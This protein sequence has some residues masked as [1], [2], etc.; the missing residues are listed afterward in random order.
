[1]PEEISKSV[2]HVV[3]YSGTGTARLKGELSPETSMEE[4]D[5]LEA[6]VEAAI[7]TAKRGDVILFSPGFASF[8]HEFKNE[9]E[10]NDKFLEFVQRYES[11]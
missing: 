2:A 7:A 10:R 11:Q 3:L 9:Y 4:H 8:N 1:L 6:C 5:T